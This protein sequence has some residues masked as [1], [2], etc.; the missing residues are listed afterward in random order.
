M[1]FAHGIINSLLFSSLAFFILFELVC[2][3]SRVGE[4][5]DEYWVD[6]VAAASENPS[7]VREVYSCPRRRTCKDRA[8]SAVVATSIANATTR[9]R[10]LASG[11]YPDVVDL[12]FFILAVPVIE[13]CD[14]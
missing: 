13:H 4:A 3:R 7:L 1:Y 5:A 2:I 12:V 8:S 14:K 10:R 11:G 6:R 9:S